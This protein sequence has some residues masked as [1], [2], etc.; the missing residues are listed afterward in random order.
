MDAGWRKL[1]LLLGT[2]PITLLDVK[3]Q[4]FT[5]IFKC[6]SYAETLASAATAAAAAVAAVKMS[7]AA[8]EVVTG[9]TEGQYDSV[10]V[11]INCDGAGYRSQGL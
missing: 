11:V 10:I 2:V 9:A 1:S 7:S 3:F 5:E 6:D 8:I 4:D